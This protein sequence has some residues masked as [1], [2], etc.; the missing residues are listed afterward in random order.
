M[1]NFGLNLPAIFLISFKEPDLIPINKQI[2]INT[3]NPLPLIG[4]NKFQK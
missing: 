4:K 3:R 2:K 1:K